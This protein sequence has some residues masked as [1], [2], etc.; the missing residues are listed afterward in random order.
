[1][2][3]NEQGLFCDMARINYLNMGNIKR[4]IKIGSSWDPLERVKETIRN[5][6]YLTSL[7]DYATANFQECSFARPVSIIPLAIIGYKRET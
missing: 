1:M 4:M 7:N 2:P 3:E 5:I 6:R